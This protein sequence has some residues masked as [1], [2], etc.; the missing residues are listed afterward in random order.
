MTNMTIPR[1]KGSYSLDATTVAMLERLAY[2]W[3]VSKSEA[4]RRAIRASASAEG[5]IDDEP[6]RDWPAPRPIARS[7]GEA[8]LR[9]APG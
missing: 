1:I 5:A 9:R 8:V 2:R 4:L 6:P 3:D 7:A